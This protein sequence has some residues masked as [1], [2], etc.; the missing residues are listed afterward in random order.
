MKRSYIRAVA[1]TLL[2]LPEPFTT[3]VGLILLIVSFFL[4]KSHK[5]NLRNVED[6]VR[7]YLKYTA[8]NG[9]NRV[10]NSNKHVAFSCIKHDSY[11]TSIPMAMNLVG[12]STTISSK[13]SSKKIINSHVTAWHEYIDKKDRAQYQNNYLNDSRL[14]NEK[15]IHHVLRTSLPQYE[16]VPGK[17]DRIV[18]PSTKI[19]L[20]P[21]GTIPYHSR[22]RPINTHSEP[23]KVVHHTL[24]RVY[25]L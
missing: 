17:N 6:L 23:T 22:L 4:P 3:P 18:Q 2:I 25:S 15:I 11:V 21:T 14:V 7:R 13:L 5:D 16:A 12:T 19:V 9:R 8:S 24:K 1:V 20:P 10:Y